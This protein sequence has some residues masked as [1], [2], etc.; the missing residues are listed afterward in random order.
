MER[1][2]NNIKNNL[3]ALKEQDAVN[4]KELRKIKEEVRRLERLNKYMR[5]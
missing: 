3:N 5:L 1:G 4:R 2:I